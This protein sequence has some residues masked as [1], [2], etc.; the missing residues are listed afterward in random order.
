MAINDALSDLVKPSA[1][2]LEP[3]FDESPCAISLITG[4]G[5]SA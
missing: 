2:A 3:S 1:R 5:A 4:S